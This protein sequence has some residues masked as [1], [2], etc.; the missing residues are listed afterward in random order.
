KRTE[1]V[2]ESEEKVD[3]RK[4]TLDSVSA[5]FKERSSKKWDEFERREELLKAK[6][7]Q[8]GTMEARI[9]QYVRENM[10]KTKDDTL[11]GRAW[12][13]A[14]QREPKRMASYNRVLKA[15]KEYA[16]GRNLKKTGREGFDL[17]R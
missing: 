16:M 10:D 15:E 8:L 2:S 5:E 4:R 12:R 9:N 11:V 7:V 17:D 3:S 13:R 6:E 14:A 1:R